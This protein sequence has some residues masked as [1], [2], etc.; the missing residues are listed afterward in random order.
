MYLGVKIFKMTKPWKE[1]DSWL[2]EQCSPLRAPYLGGHWGDCGLVSFLGFLLLLVLAKRI[3]SFGTV[4][5]RVS[6]VSHLH[7]YS[8]AAL[9]REPTMKQILLYFGLVGGVRRM[10]RGW[11][12]RSV[13]V[14]TAPVPLSSSASNRAAPLNWCVLKKDSFFYLWNKHLPSTVVHQELE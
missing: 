10:E 5:M 11:W 14:L 8:M 1:K 9:L 4:P 6:Q 3:S 7:H 12:E 2:T 13:P